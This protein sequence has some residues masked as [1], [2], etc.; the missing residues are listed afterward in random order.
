MYIYCKYKQEVQGRTDCLLSFDLTWTSLK[1]TPQTI[2]CC[3][4]NI[5]TELLPSSDRG[6][7]RPT[8]LFGET[9]TAQKM[10]CPLIL[11]LHVSVAAGMCL[12]SCC[13]EKKG[14]I[15]FTAPLPSN[16]RGDTDTDTLT[17]RQ[18]L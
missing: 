1:T 12:P 2:L 18:D 6:I 16:D 14:W 3:C 4:V 13:L 11:L 7:H 17:D 5:F 10:A 15:Q 9:L 8:D